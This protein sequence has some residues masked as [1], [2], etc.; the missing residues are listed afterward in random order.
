MILASGL[1]PAWQQILVFDEC[2]P[3]HVNRAREAHWC[4]SGKVL[5]VGIALAQL[6]AD[7]QVFSVGGG[8]PLTAMRGDLNNLGVNHRWVETLTTTRVCTTVLDTNTKIT[9]ELV[10][11]ASPMTRSELAL[12]RRDFSEILDSEDILVLTGSLPKG[13]PESYYAELMQHAPQ[14]TILDI[15]GA[16][17]MAT[18]PM[19]PF[20]VKPNVE[21]LSQTLRRPIKTPEEVSAGIDELHRHGAQWVLITQGC[22]PV[23]LASPDKRYSFVPPEAKVVNPIGCGDCLTAGVAMALAEGAEMVEAVK[24][25]MGAAA[26]NLQHLLP[27]RLVRKRVEEFKNQVVVA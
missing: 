21:E 7:C 1:T 16:E 2:T 17:L 26:D 25:G 27:G 19:K 22:G 8:W 20:L 9:T 18:L 4:A 13:T 14:R 5:N 23:L 24:F 3:G 12:Y 6:G 15:R 11:N 10:Q